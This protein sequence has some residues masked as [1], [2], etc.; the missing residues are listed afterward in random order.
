MEWNELREKKPRRIPA[1]CWVLMPSY[2]FLIIAT[3]KGEGTAGDI[4]YCLT[5]NRTAR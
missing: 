4:I 3:E 2:D 5:T 1:Q